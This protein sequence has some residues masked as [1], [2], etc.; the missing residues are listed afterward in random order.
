MHNSLDDFEYRPDPT[1]DYGISCSLVSEKSMYN[2]RN[3]ATLAPSFFIGSSFLQSGNKDNHNISDEFEIR[4]DPTTDF[5]LAA[6]E[7]L[8]NSP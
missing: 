8:V 1:T 7:R 3:V 5:E 6:I 2:R 4:L